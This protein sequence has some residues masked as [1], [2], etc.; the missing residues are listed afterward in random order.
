MKKILYVLVIILGLVIS[1]PFIK[2][3]NVYIYRE[4]HEIILEN[5]FLGE[6]YLGFNKLK[7]QSIQN[8]TL[9]CEIEHPHMLHPEDRQQIR[10]KKGIND[11]L[12]IWGSTFQHPTAKPCLLKNETYIVSVWGNNGS[13]FSTRKRL[14]ITIP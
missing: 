1:Y 9:L 11:E 12:S 3:P 10:L 7:I 2:S 14:K 8:H 4:Q 6:Y 13:G 5:I